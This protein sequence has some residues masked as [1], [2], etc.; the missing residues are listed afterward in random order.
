MPYTHL[1]K[2]PVY[3]NI[4]PEEMYNQE[5]EMSENS[6]FNRQNKMRKLEER[7]STVII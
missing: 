3:E 2:K 1:L 5:E 7:P 6:T 4:I